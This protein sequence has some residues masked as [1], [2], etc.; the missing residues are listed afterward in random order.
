MFKD[1]EYVKV[2]NA[3]LL[4]LAINKINGYFEEIN[5]TKYLTLAPNI[6]KKITKKYE[7]LWSKIKDQ[8]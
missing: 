6:E 1:L 4:Y 8:I 5:G 2:K 7:E 3:N